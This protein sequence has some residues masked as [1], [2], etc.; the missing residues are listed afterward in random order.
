MMHSDFDSHTRTTPRNH[1]ILLWL[2]KQ[3]Q[4]QQKN[5]NIKLD[6]GRGVLANRPLTIL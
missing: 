2:L 3:Q 4:Q 5:T 1:S 6:V